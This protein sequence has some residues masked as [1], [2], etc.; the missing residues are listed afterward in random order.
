M[1]DFAT[2]QDRDN[3]VK[4]N[5]DFFTVI[6][7]LGPRVGYERHEVKTL[8]EA[9]ALAGRMSTEAGRPYLIYAVAGQYDAFLK[10]VGK[11]KARTAPGKIQG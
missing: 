3:W 8:P 9:E 1:P 11:E 6:R 5:A 2:I 10:W 4:E 7:Y